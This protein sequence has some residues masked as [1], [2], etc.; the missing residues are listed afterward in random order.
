[1]KVSINLL[2]EKAKLKFAEI[3]KFKRAKIGLLIGTIIFF[4]FSSLVLIYNIQLRKQN[5]DFKSRIEAA[6]KR[7]E[8]QKETELQAFLLEERVQKIDRIL[9]ERKNFGHTLWDVFSV[10][11]PEAVVRSAE[12][13]A[14]GVQIVF[15][16]PSYQQ[17]SGFIDNF[18]EEEIKEIGG[19]EASLPSL[20]RTEEGN[21]QISLNIEF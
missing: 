21:Y 2:S 14:K 20:T 4:L 8:R 15:E 18:P 6:Q 16:L 10:L 19:K 11:P 1:M 5:A 7:V 9:K 3:E 13:K 17:A 12:A